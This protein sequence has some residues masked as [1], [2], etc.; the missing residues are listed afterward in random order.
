MK[1]KVGRKSES[2]QGLVEYL[3]IVALMAIASIG[4]M[5][6]MGQNVQAQFARITHALRGEDKQPRLQNVNRNSHRQ[7]DLSD[8]FK[9]ATTSAGDE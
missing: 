7:K 6:I 4:I 2:G 9:G 5:K 8:F 3:I 1:F